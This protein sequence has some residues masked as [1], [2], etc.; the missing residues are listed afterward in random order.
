M[1]GTYLFNLILFRAK[2]SLALDTVFEKYHWNNYMFWFLSCP[3]DFLN[4]FLISKICRFDY[5]N[6]FLI[7]KICQCDFSNDFLISKICRFDSSNDFCFWFPK[8]VGLI[9][10]MGF[11][12]QNLSVW[13][14]KWFFDFQNFSRLISWII[15]WFPKFVGLISQ[16]VFLIPK[17]CPFELSNLVSTFILR[18]FFTNCVA[19]RKAGVRA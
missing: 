18:K 10:Q 6:D 4:D 2:Q 17:I 7:T 3:F 14:L 12:S 1:P 19:Y 15:F 16:I 8:F 13:F 9:S 5:S 11:D